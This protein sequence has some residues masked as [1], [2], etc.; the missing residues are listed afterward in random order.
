M[1]TLYRGLSEGAYRQ[2]I[3]DGYMRPKRFNPSQQ[4]R[5]D[6]TTSKKQALKYGN[7][8]IAVANSKTIKAKK[9][10]G[11]KNRWSVFGEVALRRL[12]E[13]EIQT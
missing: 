10:Q 3:N 2:L 5:V 7:Y 8:A 6:F 12:K 9:N 4:P 1:T 13:L 11:V